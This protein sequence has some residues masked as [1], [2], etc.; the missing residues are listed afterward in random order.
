MA[1]KQ[2]KRE[3]T[4]TYL[5]LTVSSITACSKLL[6]RGD[7]QENGQVTVVVIREVVTPAILVYFLFQLSFCQLGALIKLMQL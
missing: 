4:Y 2:Q 6:D 5:T 7:E 3:H 1:H